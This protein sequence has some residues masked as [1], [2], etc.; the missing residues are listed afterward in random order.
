LVRDA[1]FH[2]KID[3]RE[4]HQE[5]HL[6]I[7]RVF[8]KLL[9]CVEADIYLF[10]DQDDIWQPGK[11]DATVENLLP[12]VTSPVLCFS[13]S[14]S[15]IEGK[16]QEQRRIYSA[17]PSLLRESR[18]FVAGIVGHS[19]GFTRPLREIFLNHADVAQK[20][21]HMHD[22]WM[23]CIAAACGTVRMLSQESPVALWRRHESS[24]TDKLFSR[25]VQKNRKWRGGF[26][27]RGIEK[28]RAI[29]LARRITAGYAQGL[30]A[31]SATL[32]D[33]P[34]LTRIIRVAQS[35]GK[36][37][38]RHSLAAFF[39]LLRL[40]ALVMDW[41]WAFWWAAALLSSSVK[42]DSPIDR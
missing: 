2:G 28:W 35:V 18:V 20:Y 4:W 5:Q 12:D 41:P 15:F 9:E 32:P 19:E 6:G 7:P 8:F 37:D 40:D 34:K 1:A 29:Q 39:R 42:A 24:H 13:D 21:A 33:S 11:I 38:Q 25:E 36:L 16:P 30:M 27:H 17:N 14:L 10:C 3:L 23:Y 26:D 31:A 22:M